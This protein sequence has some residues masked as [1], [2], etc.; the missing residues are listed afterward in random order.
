M[1]AELVNLVTKGATE[2]VVRL[3]T[4][5]DN[6]TPEERVRVIEL[7]VWLV[8]EGWTVTTT[9]DSVLAEAVRSAVRAMG[10]TYVLLPADGAELVHVAQPLPPLMHRMGGIR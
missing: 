7:T 6:P 4:D 1:K 3:S 10:G 9:A 8:D 5:V 2:M